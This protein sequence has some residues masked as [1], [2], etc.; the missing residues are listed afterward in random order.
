LDDRRDRLAAHVLGRVL[1]AQPVRALDGVV[2]VEAPVV[3]AHV[4]QRGGDA[5]LRGHRVA[6]GR[7]DLGDAGDLQALLGQAEGGAQ[8]G[9]AGADHEHVELVFLDLVGGHW[10]RLPATRCAA[11]RARWRWP[12]ARRRRCWRDGRY[13]PAAGCGRSPRSPPA[14]PAWRARTPRPGTP[15]ARWR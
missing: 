15:P 1:V 12:P 8:A 3:L 2:V 5:A 4:A 6:A 7:E 11:P 9:A 10:L 14:C 13:R